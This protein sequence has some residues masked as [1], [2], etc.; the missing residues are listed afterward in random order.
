MKCKHCG[1]PFTGVGS[2]IA[3]FMGVHKSHKHGDY[4]NKCEHRAP[5]KKA[6]SRKKIVKRRKSR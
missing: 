4:C 5:A 6:A 3:G 1:V 2:H